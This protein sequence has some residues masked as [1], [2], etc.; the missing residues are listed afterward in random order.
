MQLLLNASTMP[1]FFNMKLINVSDFF[2]LVVRFFFNLLVLFVLVR[3]LYFSKTKR[4]DYLFT[5]YLIGSV[6]FLICFMLSSVKLQLGFALGLFAI[7][8]I[9]RYRTT[10][11]SIR[12]MTYL[13]VVISLSVINALINKKVSYAEA[14]FANLIILGLVFLIEKVVIYRHESVKLIYYDKIDLIVPEKRDELLADLKKRTGLDIHRIEIGRI[15]FLQDSARI[16][17]YYYA[18]CINSAD[19][20][21]FTSEDSASAD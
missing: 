19:D 10:Q 9:I 11:I 6:V 5:Y 21:D 7:F 1:E 13:F 3:M 20:A 16:M 18:D 14:L 2:E 4:K 17:V 15:N 12:E 8:G